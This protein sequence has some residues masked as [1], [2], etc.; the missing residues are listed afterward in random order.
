GSRAVPGRRGRDR[1]GA[2]RPRRPRDVGTY[3]WV[4]SLVR[5]DRP[6]TRG[7]AGWRRSHT[8]TGGARVA[9]RDSRY[10]VSAAGTR[11]RGT[12][13][14]TTTRRSEERRVGDEW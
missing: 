7:R 11:P 6:A 5:C 12:S 4:R 9:P 8:L 13:L 10:R 14:S 2:G 1:G 3:A